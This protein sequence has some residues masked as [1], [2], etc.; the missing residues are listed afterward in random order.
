MTEHHSKTIKRF[1]NDMLD[2]GFMPGY[3][4][5][6]QFYD[7]KRHAAVVAAICNSSNLD[8]TWKNSEKTL[9]QRIKNSIK[10]V[11]ALLNNHKKYIKSLGYGSDEYIEDR[12][13]KKPAEVINL[14]H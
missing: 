8:C 7:P 5:S 13:P 3:G 12:I 11:S 9:E 4:V 6:G 14:R 1:F 10:A 2:L